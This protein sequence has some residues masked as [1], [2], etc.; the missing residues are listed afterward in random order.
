[1]A[2]KRSLKINDA[3]IDWISPDSHFFFNPKDP[4][5][6]KWKELAPKLPFFKEH[7]YLL[8]S[9]R[10]KVCFL[11]K[12]ALLCSAQA[13]NKNLKSQSQDN[14][15]IA[16]PLFHVA[17]VS[18]LARSFCAGSSYK[19]C[20]FPWNVKVFHKELKKKKISLCSLVPTQL[21]DLIQHNLKAPK[22]LRAVLVGGSALSPWLYKQARKL[23]WPV[24]TCYGMTE[25]GSQI[26]CAELN[27]LN[28][29]SF[30]KMKLLDHINIKQKASYTKL[31]SKSL[32][33]AYFDL[34][35][36]KIYDPKD[37]HGWLKLE[38]KI[39]LQ[40]NF[41][42]IK[43]RK[44]EELKILGERVN[45]Q[46]L[47]FLLEKL[48]QSFTG[49]YHLLAVSDLRMGFKLALVTN[50]FDL[51]KISSLTKAFNKQVLPFERIQ[52]I[53]CVPE[54]KR[55][56]LFKVRQKQLRKQLGF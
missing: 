2:I 27:S 28:K 11:S 4:L 13:V 52:D 18:I 45:L 50:S 43:G 47:S 37:S 10:G 20:A 22:S 35:Q 7:I 1:M 40:K 38:D 54:L 23:S 51:L 49:E 46:D 12:Q 56:E 17:G 53:Y 5:A 21:Y 19:Q 41:L 48:S 39:L 36:K 8:T 25:A 42:F 44:E 24:L 31:K 30:P 9:S 32:M 26:A 33:T 15:L 29:K 14:W 55:S 16:L 6:K 3:K 34:T